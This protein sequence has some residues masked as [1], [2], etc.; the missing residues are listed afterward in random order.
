MKDKLSSILNILLVVLLVVSAAV[1]VIFY[2]G[3]TQFSSDAE[4]SEQISVLGARLDTFLNWGI[5]LA[6]GCAVAA[7]VFPLINMITDPKNSK[8]SLFMIVGMVAVI[9]IAFGIAS[10]QIPTFHGYEKFFYE[11]QSMDPNRFAKYV[12]TGMWTMYIL[13]GLSLVSIVYYE[14]AKFFK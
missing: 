11:D 14:V 7:V 12:D 4:F 13:A 6:L 10:D 3:T 8:K 5:I 2:V 9:L 1:A